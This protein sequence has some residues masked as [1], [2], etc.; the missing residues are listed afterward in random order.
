MRAL[1]F[2]ALTA[3]GGQRAT[4]SPSPLPSASASTPASVDSSTPVA[5]ASS[6]T[7]DADCV[8]T[9]LGTCCT[10]C[11]E[12]PHAVSREDLE[13]RNTHCGIVECMKPSPPAG[14]CPQTQ[15]PDLYKAICSKAQCVAVKK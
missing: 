4:E 3:C 9:N 5:G 15:N 11:A 2:V 10:A 14:G 8:I 6:C 12:E 7:K 13:G 1:F